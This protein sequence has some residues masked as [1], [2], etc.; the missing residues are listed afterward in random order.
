MTNKLMK[1]LLPIVLIIIPFLLFKIFN[2]SI[3]LSDSNIYFYTAYQL[4]Q[5]KILYK[6]IFFTNFPLLPYVSVGYFLAF[7]GNLKLFFLTP[8]IE[9]SIIAALIYI[10]VL[11]QTK[12]TMPGAD[13]HPALLSA[14]S[15]LFY[16]YSFIALATSDHQSGVFLASLFA[17]VSYYFFISKRYVLTGVFIALALLTKAYF[18]PIFAAYL[19][20]LLF[21]RSEKSFSSRDARTII[22][23]LGGFLV[24]IFVILLPTLLFAYQDFIKDVFVYSLTRT[25]GVEKGRLIWFFITHDFLLFSVLIFNLYLLLKKQFF[26]FLS[27]FGIL[28]FFFYQDIYYLYLNFLVPFL[29]ISF[30]MMYEAVQKS[31]KPNR[32]LL[33]AIIGI[34]LLYNVYSYL[35]G[36]NNLQKIDIVGMTKTVR[37][38]NP[39]FIY[40]INSIAPAL[41]YTSGIPLLNGVVDT[42]PN[43]YRKGFLNS[44]RM[45]ADAIRNHALIVGEGLE[46]PMYQ[47]NETLTG[48]VFDGEK[49]KKSCKQVGSFPVQNEGPEN[50]INV[51]QC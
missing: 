34:F 20:V 2:L 29:C 26:G 31:F 30:P 46:Y 25:Q 33:P 35:S 50:R 19:A 18:I 39:K 41:A 27:L 48:E 40:G 13:L 5:G 47:V 22:L 8:A 45:T 17:I 7:F 37:E 44:E 23:F 12:N 14:L 11:R 1:K 6:D 32:Y 51:F 42:N 21:E 43:I 36:Y 24:T 4:L 10:I 3:R 49:I 16:L 38:Q 15:A 9:A 28:F